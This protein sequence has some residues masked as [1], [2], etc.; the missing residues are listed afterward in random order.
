[1][2]KILNNLITIT[3]IFIGGT[4]F[5]ILKFDVDKVQKIYSIF[6]SLSIVALAA[7]I[8]KIRQ[9]K[10]S[11]ASEQISFFREEIISTWTNFSNQIIKKN[12]KY[13]FSQIILGKD[14]EININTVKDNKNYSKNFESQI[15]LF[16]NP[17]STPIIDNSILDGHIN[18]LNKVEQFANTILSYNLEDHSVLNPVKIT[19]VEIISKNIVALLFIRDMIYSEPS[20]YVSTLNLYSL[21]KPDDY[22]SKNFF[23]TLRN[24]EKADLIT[25]QRS[26]ELKDR[27][28]N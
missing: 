6:G 21:W 18:L 15:R 28:K 9:D 13:P 27:L 10:I 7:Y 3:I 26:K 22:K 11:I 25:K 2:K 4:V 16:Y 1:M 5:F 8:Y 24:L 20:Y 19:F 17:D 12:S 14:D 23:K